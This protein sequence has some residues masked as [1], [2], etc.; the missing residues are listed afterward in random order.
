MGENGR[1]HFQWCAGQDSHITGIYDGWHHCKRPRSSRR[2]SARKTVG[3]GGM[4]TRYFLFTEAFIDYKWVCI[5]LSWKRNLEMTYESESRSYLV[6]TTDKI[7]GLAKQLWDSYICRLNCRS[8]TRAVGIVSSEASCPLRSMPCEATCWRDKPTNA[9]KDS[10]FVY[11]SGAI[12]ELLYESITQEEYIRLN[13]VGKMLYQYYVWDSSIGWFVHFKYILSTYAGKSMIGRALR[14]IN[15]QQVQ[16]G[17]F[18]VL[19][20]CLE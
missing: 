1:R 12:E 2:T 15:N 3:Q 4:S 10:V 20:E 9:I 6:Q 13:E 14:W 17:R 11:E 16:S 5:N 19:G 7:E 18:G 8:A